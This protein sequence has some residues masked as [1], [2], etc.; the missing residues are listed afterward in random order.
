MLYD[1][2]R[3]DELLEVA[4]DMRRVE[5]EHGAAQPGGMRKPTPPSC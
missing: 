3:W 1:L 2:G 5:E 4:E